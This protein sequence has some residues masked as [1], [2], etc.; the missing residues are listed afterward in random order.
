VYTFH[1][2]F[3]VRTPD[4]R[5]FGAP[6]VGHR[7]GPFSTKRRVKIRRRFMSGY[8]LAHELQHHLRPGVHKSGAPGRPGDRIF[9]QWS[10]I[11]SA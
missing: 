10:Q 1:D 6:N 11:F 5:L 3:E 2:V 9:V 8:Y 4:V 7:H